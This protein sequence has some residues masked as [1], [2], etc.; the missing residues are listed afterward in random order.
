MPTDP[1]GQ[2]APA[3]GAGGGEGAPPEGQ[4]PEGAP[5]PAAPLAPGAPA[6]PPAGETT[7]EQLQAQLVEQRKIQAGLDKRVA[8]LTAQ[9]GVEAKAK[10][11]LT[12]KLT[13]AQTGATEG[14][15]ELDTLRQTVAA[16]ET[17]KTVWE[18]QLDATKAQTERIRVVAA[19][20][21]ALAPLVE[22]GALPEAKDMDEFRQKL[23]TMATALNAQATAAFQQ[24]AAGV[25]PPA[26]PPAASS[27]AGAD[28]DSLH[29]QMAVA[30]KDRQMETYNALRE[31]WY[32]ATDAQL[33]K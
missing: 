7:A 18:G 9:L 29:A 1:T 10:E 28:L 17:E 33:P 13:A 16:L 26:S 11:D 8:Q 31:R 19:E 14:T 27:P 4:P 3:T 15:Q 25:K 2:G 21:P 22:A 12:T 32:A 5:P 6:P 20:F 23:T 30:L 24:L